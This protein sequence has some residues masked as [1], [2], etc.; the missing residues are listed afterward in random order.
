[1][2]LLS[3]RDVHWNQNKAWRWFLR[4][5]LGISGNLAVGVLR[6]AGISHVILGYSSLGGMV[7]AGDVIL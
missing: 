2:T 5:S 4:L 3:S 6:I 7:G 1:M